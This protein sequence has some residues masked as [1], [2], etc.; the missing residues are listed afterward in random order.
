[1]TPLYSLLRIP[2]FL[3][4]GLN[5]NELL[6]MAQYLM[7]FGTGSYVCGGLNLAQVM[8]KMA[9]AAVARNFDIVAPS[10]TN[11]KT[12]EMRDSF[13]SPVLFVLVQTHTCIGGTICFS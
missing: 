8:L 4:V 5:G 9:V 7:P 3:N 13:V 2:S 10:E 6:R 1:M 11:E 12:M